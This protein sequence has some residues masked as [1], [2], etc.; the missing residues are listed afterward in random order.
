MSL[1]RALLLA[2]IVVGG[3]VT[4]GVAAGATV[5]DG[6]ERVADDTADRDGAERT[7]SPVPADVD[8]A[9]VRAGAAAQDAANNSTGGSA[10]GAD[11]S[12][13]MQTSAA[14]V[15]GAVETGMWGAAF[16]GTENRSERVR[17]VERRTEE[18]NS[19]LAEL[20]ERKAELVAERAAGNASE[21]AYKAKI[22]GLVGRIN[23][24]ES[25]VDATADRA[26]EV[27][28]DPEA[29]GTLRT[30][31][32]NLSGPELAAVARNVT[33]VG[34]TPVAPGNGR[35]GPANGERPGAGNANGTGNGLGL[36]NGTDLGNG[37]AVGDGDRPGVGSEDAAGNATGANGAGVG[38]EGN[39]VTNVGNGNRGAGQSGD[40]D[41]P[42]RRGNGDGNASSGGPGSDGTPAGAADGV[43]STVAA[44][45]GPTET[46]LA[47]VTAT[48][49]LFGH[50]STALEAPAVAPAA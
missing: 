31:T 39:N 28:V 46:V 2:L 7:A 36:E 47:T 13:F 8:A 15:D 45:D 3:A 43:R 48:P 19:T 49:G 20:R 12:A 1:Y 17:L 9:E 34:T 18:L 26:E 16:N 50:V 4:A 44:V 32:A 27:G 14:E 6:A 29:L 35:A 11:I 40:G 21:A 22:S 30:A 25:A 23:A 5:H 10:L 41:P 33:G 24:L 38:S 42:S 37:T